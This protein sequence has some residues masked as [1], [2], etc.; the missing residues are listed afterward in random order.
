MCTWLSIIAAFAGLVVTVPVEACSCPMPG[1]V[2]EALAKATVVFR[3]SAVSVSV[4]QNPI[5]TNTVR[6]YVT[7]R[8]TVQVLEVWKGSLKVGDRV[9]VESSVGVGACG[10]SLTNSPSSIDEVLPGGE[11]APMKLSGEWIIF[12]D[13]EQPFQVSLCSLS[14]PIEAAGGLETELREAIRSNGT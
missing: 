10:R 14:R 2:R 9:S 4:D 12:A 1:S 3:G 8:A 6:T 7:E 5:G 13:G 11:I